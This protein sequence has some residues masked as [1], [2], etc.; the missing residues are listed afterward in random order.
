M[1]TWY[2]N[3]APVERKTF[4][5][6]FAGWALDALDLQMLGLIIPALTATFVLTRV[7]AGLISSLTLVASALGGWVT[8]SLSD[9][10]G[11]VRT[12]QIA[13]LWF[14]IFTFLSAF[15]QN[16]DQF[17]ALKTLQGF[18]FGGEWTAGSVLISEVIAARF[19]GRA[20]S[21]TQSAY[22]VGWGSAV[23]FYAL[24]FSWFEHDIA[25][26]V[27][28]A[29]GL[30]PGLLVLYIR[31]NL[32]EP[33]RQTKSAELRPAMSL[34]AIFSRSTLRATLIG[35]LVGVGAHGGF[36]VLG[37]WLPTFLR[38]A[39]HL[40]V[41]HTSG[42]L[43]VLIF[44]FFCGFVSV[45]YLLDR[46]GRRLTIVLFA[47]ACTSVIVLYTILPLTNQ[48]ML[49]MGFP[50]GFF[51]AGIPGSMG[52]L[53]TELYPSGIRGSGVGFCYNFGRVLSAAFPV[54]VGRLSENMP[55]GVSIGI[56]AA[57]GYGIVALAVW[58]LP[59]TRGRRFE[60]PE[61]DC[62]VPDQS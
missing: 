5:A 47:I 2:T 4:W 16:Y 60:T 10:I 44:A 33:H 58:F 50:L 43:A 56:C 57:L 37:T 59:E 18:G 48:Q 61:S 26:R 28:L 15:A 51:A 62:F 22:S 3:S 17:I 1:F 45:G 49:F 8:G 27:M 14:S 36:A 55:L 12:L 24:M 39:R 6:C 31:R 19:R 9:R 20:M 25:W 34:T 40:S 53:F 29:A 41:M 35:G 42:Y 38:T 46:F 11:R 7:E 32:P 52:A 23:V 13:V 30:L 54:M 21:A